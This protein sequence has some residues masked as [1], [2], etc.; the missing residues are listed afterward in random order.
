MSFVVVIAATSCSTWALHPPANGNISCLPS[1]SENGATCVAACDHG[2]RFID[3]EPTKTLTCQDKNQWLPGQIV[4]DCIP[5]QGRQAAYDVVPHVTYRPFGALSGSCRD[6][7]INHISSSYKIL[8]D[9]LSKRCSSV[10]VDMKVDFHDTIVNISSEND[11]S[12]I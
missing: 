5:A 2:Y 4:P 10:N 3:G 12:S 1:G 11:V 7:Y 9:V 8:S 6:T